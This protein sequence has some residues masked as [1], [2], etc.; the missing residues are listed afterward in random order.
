MAFLSPPAAECTSADS[1]ILK[2]YGML[3]RTNGD[4]HYYQPG[5]GTYVN[6]RSISHTSK[7]ARFNSWYQKAKDSAVGTSF[8][9][10]VMG[11]Y[12][13]LMQCYEDDDI[14]FFG[15]SRGAYVARFLAE[16]LDHVGL[17][18]AGNEEMI[19]FA[20]KAFARWQQRE[21]N[22]VEEK[23]KKK[24]MLDFLLAFRETFSRPVRRIRFLGLFDT[25]NSVPRFENAWMQRSKFPYTAR[26]SAR[27]IRHAVSIDERRAKFRSDLISEA[28]TS[29]PH[30]KHQGESYGEKLGSGGNWMTNGSKPS[31]V[32]ADRFRRRSQF[33]STVELNKVVSPRL[34]A[35][36]EG[37]LD[38]RKNS[39]GGL[40]ST[41][42]AISRSATPDGVSIKTSTSI[43]SYQPGQHPDDDDDDDEDE[44]AEQDIEELW[45][46]GCHADLGGGWPLAN[47]EE[48][49]LSHGPLV[50]MVR[51]AQRAGLEF[52]GDKLLRFRCC[53]ENYNISSLEIAS[54]G[55]SMPQ[56][57]VSQPF[58][59][60]KSEKQEPG[61]AAGMEPETPPKSIFLQTL[62][63]A[64]TKGVLHDCLEFNNGL[65]IASVLSWRM[66]EY[67]PFRRMDLR[68][69][70]SWK[71][72]S[73]PLPMGEVRD[74]PENA[75]IHH[76][77][78]QRMEADETYRPGNL[79]IGGGG[80]GVKRA[81]KALGIGEWEILKG[82]D[83]PVGMV[84]VRK[85]PSLEKQI[86]EATHKS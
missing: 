20:W 9:L 85:G 28:K 7:L 62:S 43:D 70:G 37:Y 77:A 22:T 82:K 25:V 29:R 50:W 57:Q 26:S 54:D 14:F 51:E 4:K 66:M 18:S 48:S 19:R 49:P 46:P 6:T 33:R 44:A 36:E 15:F 83:D 71:A 73:M 72:I 80:R 61:W 79:I 41:S 69:D 78:I 38:P 12:K 21:E 63:T 45:F 32:S 17:L 53:D 35:V 40:R 65:G 86:D 8:D 13:F 74:M 76:S 58:S 34:S 68:P 81:P 59:S 84:Y 27:V 3:D 23:K 30:E 24:E 42:P 55:P 75:W 67:L 52:D 11:A 39:H 2:I 56:I 64:A 10:H 31:P 60:P 47:G 16:M 5:I 1:N